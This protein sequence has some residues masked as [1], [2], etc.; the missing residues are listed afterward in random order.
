MTGMHNCV[1]ANHR[2]RSTRDAWRS[3][4]APPD[5]VVKLT[6]CSDFRAQEATKGGHFLDQ[7]AS[8]PLLR[9]NSSAYRGPQYR[10]PTQHPTDLITEF[11]SPATGAMALRTINRTRHFQ[12]AYFPAPIRGTSSNGIKSSSAFNGALASQVKRSYFFGTRTVDHK[13]TAGM[14]TSGHAGENA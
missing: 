13:N 1:E 8:P 9:Y 6:T 2:T 14:V 7:W 4:A 3:F 11:E 12:I 5:R 10:R